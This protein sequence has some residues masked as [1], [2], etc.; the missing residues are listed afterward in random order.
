MKLDASEQ[1]GDGTPTEKYWFGLSSEDG[2]HFNEESELQYICNVASCIGVCP[3]T[4][5][6]GFTSYHAVHSHTP[7]KGF[8]SSTVENDSQNRIDVVYPS[9]SPTGIPVHVI[10]LGWYLLVN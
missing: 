7:I 6:A 5:T 2:I 8:A 4:C 3:A 1:E 10:V 9:H